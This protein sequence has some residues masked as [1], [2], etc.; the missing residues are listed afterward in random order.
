M[1]KFGMFTLM[2]SIMLIL[3]ACGTDNGE[4]LGESSGNSAGEGKEKYTVGIDTT[5]PPFEF[6]VDGEYDRD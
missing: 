2:L 1:K 6:E 4:S 5:Y 3:A